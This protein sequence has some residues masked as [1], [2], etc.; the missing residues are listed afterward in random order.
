[1]KILTTIAKVNMSDVDMLD[2]LE[3]EEDVKV[4]GS[5]LVTLK[6]LVTSRIM[7]VRTLIML[8]NW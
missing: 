2:E 8:L 4:K 7:V 3:I 5:I 1:M 6:R